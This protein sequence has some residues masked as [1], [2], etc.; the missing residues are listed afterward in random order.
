MEKHDEPLAD[1]NLPQSQTNDFTHE[2]QMPGMLNPSCIGE[3]RPSPA[4]RS[5]LS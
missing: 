2:L 1:E 5:Q 4:Y 3:L